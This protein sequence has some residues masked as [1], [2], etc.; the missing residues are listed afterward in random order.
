QL[1]A[2]LEQ[3]I[4]PV[5]GAQLLDLDI[6]PAGDAIERITRLYGVGAWPIASRR[7]AGRGV[8]GKLGSTG[9]GDD[10]LLPDM[11]QVAV[12]VVARR[13]CFPAGAVL[14]R[15]GRQVVTASYRVAA[16]GHALAVGQTGQGGAQ[17]LGLGYGYEQ[18]VRLA[19]W[20]NP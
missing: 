1:L 2:G 4:H 13:Q 5:P 15:D 6:E 12:R 17:L 7:A 8:T 16:E 14:T 11:A 19:R 18:L 9:A 3:S 10:Q 20:G